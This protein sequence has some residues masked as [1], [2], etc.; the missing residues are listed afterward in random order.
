MV[1]EHSTTELHHQLFRSLN[2]VQKKKKSQ[3][4]RDSVKEPY[5]KLGRE[6]NVD[7]IKEGWRCNG[8]STTQMPADLNFQHKQQ[9]QKI[10]VKAPCR[11]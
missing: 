10:G 2:F 9:S 5:N 1:G 8:E 6:D 7:I 4:L 11:R 3:Q